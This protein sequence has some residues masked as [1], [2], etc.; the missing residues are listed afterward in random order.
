MVSTPTPPTR[1]R[2]PAA[3]A[4]HDGIRPDVLEA[5]AHEVGHGLCWNA[6]AFGIRHMS[7]RTGLFGGID[8]YCR[9]RPLFLDEHNIDPYLIGLAG[10]AAG[11]IRH[12]TAH[13]PEVWGARGRAHA[14][15]SHDRAEFHRLGPAHGSALSWSAAVAAA[16]RII[17]ARAA[18]H[19]RLTAALARNG[20]L[21]GSAL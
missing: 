10:G 8:A 2:N 6:G 15:A 12:L 1:P 16:G 11:Q 20:R 4:L 13:Q 21:P 9:R 18:D 5:A 17:A 19:D 7:V 3:H 14:N